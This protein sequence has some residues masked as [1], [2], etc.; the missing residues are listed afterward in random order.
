MKMNKYIKI[1]SN[2]KF[3]FIRR[4]FGAS[5]FKLLD[6]GSGNHSAS[7]ITYLFPNCEY[8]GLDLNKDYNNDPK[9]FELMKNFYQLDLTK[10]EYSII[11]D[12]YFD[13]I[14]MAHVVEHLYNGDRVI[15]SLIRKLRPGGYM[16]VEYPGEKS[17]HL[18]SMNGTLNFYDDLSHVRIYSVK[19]LTKLFKKSGCQVIEGGIR[20]NWYYLLAMPFRIIGFTLKGKKLIGNMFWDL[21][22]FAEYVYV[23]KDSS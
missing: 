1:V 15:E 4:S 14:W 7:R 9:D 11:P 19:E 12:E 13:G 6:V 21:L 8:Y 18:P 2:L 20:R 10:L 5:R 22:G 17:T 23:Q 3:R 16:Y